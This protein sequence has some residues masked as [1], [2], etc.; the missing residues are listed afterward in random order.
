MFGTE[1]V[2]LYNKDSG[3]LKLI[4][5]EDDWLDSELFLTDCFLNFSGTKS[6]QK[7]IPNPNFKSL[8]L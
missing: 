6:S 2:M 1:F 4:K 8:A 3:V 5:I 7:W